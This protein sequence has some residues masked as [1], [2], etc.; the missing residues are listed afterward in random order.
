MDDEDYGALISNVYPPIDF[1]GILGF[2]NYEPYLQDERYSEA[3]IFCGNGDSV[4]CHIIS[5]LSIVNK[6]NIL[7]RDNMMRIFANSL[8]KKAWI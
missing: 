8:E 4:V 7:H 1:S 2:P 5:F 6:F 3:L